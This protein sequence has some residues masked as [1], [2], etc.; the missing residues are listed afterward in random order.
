MLKIPIS[1]RVTIVIKM[2]L[3]MIKMTQRKQLMREPDCELRVLQNN[4]LGNHYVNG[5]NTDHIIK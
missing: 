4:I 3:K 5:Y 1:F 2:N